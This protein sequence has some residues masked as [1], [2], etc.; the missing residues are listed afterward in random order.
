MSYR[1]Q[2]IRA[3]N[4]RNQD[5][6]FFQLP[7]EGPYFERLESEIIGYL[8]EPGAAKRSC[9]EWDAMLADAAHDDGFEACLPIKL[10]QAVLEQ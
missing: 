2:I 7:I 3:I 9:E 6:A 8:N 10:A 5:F 1:A 4:R